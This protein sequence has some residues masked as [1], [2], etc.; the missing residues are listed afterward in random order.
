MKY[1]IIT[2]ET[3]KQ[4]IDLVISKQCTIKQAASMAG[5][6]FSTSKAILKT[7][8]KEGRIGKKTQRIKKLRQTEQPN[9]LQLQYQQQLL[10]NHHILMMFLSQNTF[11]R[12]DLELSQ[13]N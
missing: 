12:Q 8:R 2:P 7:F 13:K 6:K 3:R 11:F 1:D 9:I 5:I 10:F 4:F